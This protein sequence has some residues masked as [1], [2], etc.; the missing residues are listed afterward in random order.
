MADE[1]YWEY[2]ASS[3]TPTLADAIWAGAISPK[4]TLEEWRKL[5]P[6]M[7]REIVRAKTK[8]NLK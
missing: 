1:A 4:T 8:N 2:K 7:R 5:S 6:G 3:P